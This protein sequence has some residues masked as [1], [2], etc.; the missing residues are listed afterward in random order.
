MRSC[1]GSQMHLCP[2][3][4]RYLTSS[5]QICWFER[6]VLQVTPINPSFVT[7]QVGSGALQR[8]GCLP[9]EDLSECARPGANVR[10][11][12]ECQQS[13]YSTCSHAMLCIFRVYRNTTKHIDIWMIFGILCRYPSTRGMAR[14]DSSAVV[15]NVA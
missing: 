8:S 7:G 12:S 15:L 2:W 13:C 9:T 4:S 3:M 14:R 1:R 5:Q 11:S 6:K 10:I